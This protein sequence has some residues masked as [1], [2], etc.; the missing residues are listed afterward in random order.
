MPIPTVDVACDEFFVLPI[1]FVIHEDMRILAHRA[2]ATEPAMPLL[3]D[4]SHRGAPGRRRRFSEQLARSSS[5]HKPILNVTIKISLIIKTC[6]F[7][8]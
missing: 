4:A 1:S 2:I 3:F 8:Y 7:I 5:L 6:L